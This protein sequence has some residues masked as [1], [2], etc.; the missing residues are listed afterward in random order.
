MAVGE[1]ES[2][3]HRGHVRKTEAITSNPNSPVASNR[4]GGFKEESRVVVSEGLRVVG[5]ADGSVLV[6]FRNSLRLISVTPGSTL[7]AAL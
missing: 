3:R 4:G 1:F 6:N 2:L 5:S 7:S